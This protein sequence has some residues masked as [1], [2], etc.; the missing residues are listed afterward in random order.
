MKKNS[1]NHWFLIGAIGF[2]AC[3]GQ[4]PPVEAMTRADT[5]V[6]KAEQTNAVV[7][8]PLEMR[9]AREKLDQ[10][11]KDMNA[12]KYDSARKNAEDATAQ[13]E[14]AESKTDLKDTKSKSNDAEQGLKTLQNE[15][16]HNNEGSVK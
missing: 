15:I 12:K 16:Q 5:A 6:K 13:A 11:Q 7:A 2:F 3:A 14:L 9:L 4:K 10:A 1:T 8:A